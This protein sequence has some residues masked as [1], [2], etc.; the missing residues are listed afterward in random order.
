[1]R[2]VFKLAFWLFAIAFVLW[3][4]MMYFGPKIVGMAMK[5]PGVTKV[6]Q[7]TPVPADELF[8]Q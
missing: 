2:F 4:T 1:L 5:D 3:L 7:G 8:G 6:Q